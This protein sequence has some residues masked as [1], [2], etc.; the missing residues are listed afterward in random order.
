MLRRGL[1]LASLFLATSAFAT[2]NPSFS[3]R[4][5]ELTVGE[6]RT[7]ELRAVW[8]GLSFFEFY[9]WRCDSD[10][11]QVA[12]VEGGLPALGGSG[13]VR[14]TAIAPGEAGIRLWVGSATSPMP[15]TYVTI[16]VRPNP[17]TVSIV[18][19]AWTATAGQ[20]VTLTASAAGS[21]HTFSWYRGRLGDTTQPLPGTSNKLIVT[22]ATPGPAYY[23]VFAEAVHGTN[24]AEIAIDVKPPPRRRAAGH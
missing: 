20:P 22:P 18:P 15:N 19:S 12:H 24:R 11:E 9:G 16:V 4:Y 10:T 3:S 6:T 17:V 2:W 1:L 21:P 8:S 5:E 23:W 14:I 7:I 13:E